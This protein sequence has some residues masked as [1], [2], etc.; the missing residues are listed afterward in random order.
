MKGFIYTKLKMVVMVL[1]VLSVVGCAT[2]ITE[3]PAPPQKATTE[4]RAFNKV[5]LLKSEM[6]VEYQESEANQ[7]AVKKIDEHLNNGLRLIFPDLQVVNYEDRDSV[8]AQAGG[9]QEVLIIKPFI[10]Q[11][12]FI[13]GATRF[14][15]GAMAGSSVVIMDVDYEDAATGDSVAKAGFLRK[16]NAYAGSWS[17]GAAD[18]MMLESIA[19]DVV[20]YSSA[21]R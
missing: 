20:N 6:A 4:F 8:K 21:N 11:I 13:G 3:E 14:W 7:K 18:N 17:I 5:V 2:Q 9:A 10:K 12:K 16:G 19:Q 15:V 1:L